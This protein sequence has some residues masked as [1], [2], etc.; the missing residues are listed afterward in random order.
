MSGVGVLGVVVWPPYI[1]LAVCPVGD[2]GPG[3]V[4]VG[5]PFG[6]VNYARG[7]IRWRTEVGG[8][9]VGG[10]DVWLPAGVFT[11]VVFFSGPHREALMGF[12]KVEHPVVFDRPGMTRVDP[13]QNQDF[14]PRRP[15]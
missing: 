12:K 4:A 2:P 8:D 9:V 3:P 11:H 15:A 10:A 1:G 5:E 6:D 7:M 13:I 14:L